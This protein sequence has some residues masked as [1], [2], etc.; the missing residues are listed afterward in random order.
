M[1]GSR[2][3]A[4]GWRDPWPALS[5]QGFLMGLVGGRAGVPLAPVPFLLTPETVRWVRDALL[6]LRRGEVFLGYA[7]LFYLAP[8]VLGTYATGLAG[9]VLGSLLRGRRGGS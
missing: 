8:L 5:A 9:A 4:V 2:L 7:A 6:D 3:D 1:G